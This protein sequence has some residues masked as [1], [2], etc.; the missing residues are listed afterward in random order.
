MVMIQLLIADGYLLVAAVHDAPLVHAV[1]NCP[2]L[3]TY[4]I[5]ADGR[6]W[7][8]C[9]ASSLTVVR[10]QSLTC[11]VYLPDLGRLARMFS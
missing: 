10:A 1:L 2:M 8:N 3:F 6:K 11:V 5:S 9:Q 4:L 7:L